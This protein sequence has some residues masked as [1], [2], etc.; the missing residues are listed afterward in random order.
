ELMACA[1]LETSPFSTPR[2][3][4][5]VSSDH[6]VATRCPLPSCEKPTITPASLIPLAAEWPVPRGVSTCRPVS[7]RIACSWWLASTAYPTPTLCTLIPVATLWPPQG[8]GMSSG[9][10]APDCR[11]PWYSPDT[12]N[13]A[14]TP[15][16]L[17]AVAVLLLAPISRGIHVDTLLTLS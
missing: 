8:S 12:V 15:A 5:C 9:G 7:N 13:P 11:K 16:A 10:S 14:T 1:W 2:D 17:I 6:R 4:G 3:C